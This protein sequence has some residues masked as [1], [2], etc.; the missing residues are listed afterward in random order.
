[1]GIDDEEV[2]D[3][4]LFG[5]DSVDFATEGEGACDENTVGMCS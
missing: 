1:M 5:F 3:F 4:D 2:V